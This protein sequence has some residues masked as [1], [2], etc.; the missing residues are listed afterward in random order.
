MRK[1]RFRNISI[2]R[3]ICMRSRRLQAILLNYLKILMITLKSAPNSS[4]STLP[5][6]DPKKH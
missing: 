1:S 6:P 5:L 4:Y 3:K 2:D